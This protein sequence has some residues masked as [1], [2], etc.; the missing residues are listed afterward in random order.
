MNQETQILNYML[1]GNSISPLEALSKFR[2]WRLSGRIF[3]LRKQNYPI[4]T[5]MIGKGQKTY[6]SY[7]ISEDYKPL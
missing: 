4:I 5:T 6:A 7:S 2:C 3:D 1:K